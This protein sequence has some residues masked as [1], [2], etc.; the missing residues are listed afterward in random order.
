MPP[1]SSTSDGRSSP[2]APGATTIVFSPPASTVDQGDARRP[3][4]PRRRSS[5]QPA[6]RSPG[7]RLTRER[8][9]ADRADEADLGAQ[10]GGGDRLVRT[11]ASRVALE[12]S[13]R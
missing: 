13:R 1:S 5:A 7:E 6:S 11:L 12:S 3:G 8:V 9:V 4:R 10:P 2:L